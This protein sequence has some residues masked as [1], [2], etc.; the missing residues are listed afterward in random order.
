MKEM[1]II[2]VLIIAILILLFISQSKSNYDINT[3]PVITCT[4]TLPSLPVGSTKFTT[5]KVWAAQCLSTDASTDKGCNS[6][7]VTSPKMSDVDAQTL[8]SN[9]FVAFNTL[10]GGKASCTIIMDKFNGN[11]VSGSVIKIGISMV[12]DKGG[13]G[14]FAYTRM[15]LPAAMCGGTTKVM[16]PKSSYCPSDP[17]KGAAAT[18]STDSTK[19]WN[20]KKVATK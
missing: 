10:A 19:E 7:M 6:G 1:T 4:F 20:Y 13:I 16:C 15:I 17:S 12:S 11:T 9:T 14:D 2:I 3:P 8:V 5:V 18:C